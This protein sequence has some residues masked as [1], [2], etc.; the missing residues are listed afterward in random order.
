MHCVIKI[1]S[2]SDTRAH[3]QLGSTMEESKAKT[4]RAVSNGAE[5]LE[6]YSKSE[7]AKGYA[8]QKTAIGNRI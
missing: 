7:H 3:E 5:L 1:Y 4:K 8:L 6:L 2:N